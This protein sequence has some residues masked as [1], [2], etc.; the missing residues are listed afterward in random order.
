MSSILDEDKKITHKA[1]ADRVEKK[2][3]DPKYLTKELNVPASFD[4][5][6]LDWA[7]V[8]NVQSTLR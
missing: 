7:F 3:D 6:Q 8:P 5:A 1:L 4:A 2:L